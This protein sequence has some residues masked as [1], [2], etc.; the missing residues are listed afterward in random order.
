MPVFGSEFSF[1]WV[2]CV[3]MKASAVFNVHIPVYVLADELHYKLIL[4]PC[5]LQVCHTSD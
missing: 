2:Q 4:I 5:V 3:N 1:A